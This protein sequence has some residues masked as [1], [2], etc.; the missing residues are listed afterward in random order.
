MKKLIA[1]SGSTRTSW[2]LVDS[3]KD[4]PTL[5]QPVYTQGL[6][7]LYATADEIA[8]TALQV[9]AQTGD[10][11]PDLIQFYG[12]G[13]SGERV[14]MVED[15]L[16]RVVTPATRIEV[17][18][19]L[20]CACRALYPDP[21]S[22]A[23]DR[24]F[25]Y[26]KGIACIM[27]T[28]S[29][30]A[31]YDAMTD[32]MEAAP[33]LGYILGDEGSGAWLGRQVLSDYLKQQ[34]P[35]SIR[36]IFEEDYGVGAI[37]AESVIQHVYKNPFPNRYLASFAVFVG[38]HLEYGYCKNLAYNGVDAFFRRNIL[39]LNPAPAEPISFVGSV[40]YYLRN[41]L[42]M[43]SSMHDLQ[44]GQILKEPMEGLIRVRG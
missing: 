7:P 33:S 37:T 23:W 40:A 35:R 24:H 2:C 39:A 28:G 10:S 41:I 34:M 44:F 17:A 16:R 5:V 26:G 42:E 4:M 19:D 14:Q 30:A 21:R 36:N 38:Q 18:S 43:V 9:M 1:D 25:P 3:D 22:E 8:D 11:Y 32:T 13:C 6:N 15:A 12:A 27:G 29:I 20:L 31:R